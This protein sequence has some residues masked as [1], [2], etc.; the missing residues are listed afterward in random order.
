[1]SAWKRILGGNEHP[2]MEENE[3]EMTGATKQS[4]GENNYELCC[5]KDL[6]FFFL[7]FRLV[8][9]GSRGYFRIFRY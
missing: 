2:E 3:G 1:M 7:E 5:K 6:M 8:H 9:S 4:Q